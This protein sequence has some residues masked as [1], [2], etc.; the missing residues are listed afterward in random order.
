MKHNKS[1]SSGSLKSPHDRCIT[2]HARGLPFVDPFF[3]LFVG[4]MF[5]ATSP[6]K[7]SPKWM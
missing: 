1:P 5:L 2:P 7:Q 4:C 3:A 6:P